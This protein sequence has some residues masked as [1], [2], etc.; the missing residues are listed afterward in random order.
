MNNRAILFGA[1]TIGVIIIVALAVWVVSFF[2]NGTEE[3]GQ[4][5]DLFSSLFPFGFGGGAGTNIPRDGSREEGGETGEVPR[6]RVISGNPTSG[7]RITASGSVRY[8]ERETGHIYEAAL[9]SYETERISN[10]TMP[11]AQRATWVDDY[12]LV[13]QYLSAGN[14]LES[15][16]VTL[17]TTTPEEPAAA[18][19]LGSFSSVLPGQSGGMIAVTKG[20]LGTNVERVDREGTASAVLFASPLRSWAMLTG[21]S[22][23]FLATSPSSAEGFLYSVGN[24]QRLDKIA[25]RVPGLMAIPSPNGTWIAYSSYGGEPALIAYD[26]ATGARYSAFITTW[27]KKCAWFPNEPLLF[28]G[29]PNTFEGATIE[30]WLMG[31]HSFSDSAWIIDPVSGIATV[32]SNLEDDAGRAIDMIEPQVSQDGRYAIFIN[33]NDLSL[34]SLRLSEK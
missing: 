14:D 32:V 15:Y 28:C 8:A 4:E 16:L 2:S 6:L 21:G 25:G 29:V 22:G 26:T 1:L 17:S 24:N 9:D 31:V 20:I 13:F 19:Y 3:P 7:A 23:I 10:A 27:A 30:G 11:G 5:Q 18:S 34:W 12:T 33:K